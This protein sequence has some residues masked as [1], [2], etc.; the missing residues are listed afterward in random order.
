MDT[1]EYFVAPPI[2]TRP[3]TAAESNRDTSEF[4]S[5]GVRSDCYPNNPTRAPEKTVRHDCPFA[6]HDTMKLDG[7]HVN[8]VGK[9]LDPT[10]RPFIGL[11]NNETK[12]SLFGKKF[13]VSHQQL[14][15]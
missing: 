6:I 1:L 7:A 3:V 9:T 4:R 2:Y 14:G 8:T 5:N 13:A 11:V 12:N 10:A 15:I